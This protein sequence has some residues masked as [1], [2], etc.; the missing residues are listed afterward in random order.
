MKKKRTNHGNDAI[1]VNILD[2]TELRY[3]T[4]KLGCTRD[5][6]RSDVKQ[7]GDSLTAVQQHLALAHSLP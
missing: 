3:W 6:I 7:S 5:E 1:I 2:G 4:E